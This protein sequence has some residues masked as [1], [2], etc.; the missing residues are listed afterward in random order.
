MP[1]YYLT[2]SYIRSLG[3]VYLISPAQDLISLKSRFQPKY[4]LIWTSGPLP[5]S[6]WLLAEFRSCGWK[7]EVPIFLLAIGQRSHSG[8]RGWSQVLYFQNKARKSF[9]ARKSNIALTGIPEGKKRVMEENKIANKIINENF[10]R[11]EG[12]MSSEWKKKTYWTTSAKKI[13]DPHLDT[14]CHQGEEEGTKMFQR[15]IEQTS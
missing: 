13:T 2:V 10:L 9:K 4:D 12:Y 3:I 15:G 7:T 11:L 14:S 1:I 6:F 8:T 5:N